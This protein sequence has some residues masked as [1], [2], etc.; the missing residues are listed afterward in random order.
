MNR[1]QSISKVP[2]KIN[3]QKPVVELV[4][5]TGQDILTVSK[6]KD[7]DQGEWDSQSTVQTYYG[8]NLEEN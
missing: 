4:Q 1:Y 8:Y 3:Y 2:P 6:G 5:F 7:E